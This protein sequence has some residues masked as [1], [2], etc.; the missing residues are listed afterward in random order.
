MEKLKIFRDFINEAAFDVETELMNWMKEGEEKEVSP[1]IKAFIESKT[2]GNVINLGGA[3]TFCISFRSEEDDIELVFVKSKQEE[4]A[5]AAAFLK[6]YEFELENSEFKK[7]DDTMYYAGES[8]Y[9]SCYDI[10]RDVNY[11]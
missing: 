8:L 1:E 4:T 5:I 10:S 11:L 7:K 6:L 9:Y 2:K 3:K